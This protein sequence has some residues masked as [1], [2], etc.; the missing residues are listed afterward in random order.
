MSS[1]KSLAARLLTRAFRT[2]PA[3]PIRK[4]VGP[5]GGRIEV[6]ED[7]ITPVAGDLDAAFGTGGVVTTSYSPLFTSGRGAALQPDGKVV[8]VGYANGPNIFESALTRYNADG[9]LDGTFGSGGKIVANLGGSD[10]LTA[11][12]VQP[13]GKIVVAGSSN[14]GGNAS[15]NFTVAR[16]TSAGVLDTTFGTAA[17]GIVVVAFGNST[18]ATALAIQPDGKIV[19]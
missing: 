4:P 19:A 14:N 16:Y 10:G 7:R 5:V 18:S 11:V 13:D 2:R 8:V 12:A 15:Y 6:L 1:K 17:T 9:S 3:A